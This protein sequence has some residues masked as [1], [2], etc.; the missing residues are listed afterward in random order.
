MI[1]PC[2][3]LQENRAFC[4]WK[5]KEY[6][7]TEIHWRSRCKN[8]S[9]YDTHLRTYAYSLT[10]LLSYTT[11]NCLN[12]RVNQ[13]SF[14]K[15]YIFTFGIITRKSTRLWSKNQRS[16]A[17][18]TWSSLY[19]IQHSL[20]TGMHWPGMRLYYFTIPPSQRGGTSDTA[21][22]LNPHLYKNHIIP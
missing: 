4:I 22:L 20:L 1:V 16:K 2:K 5:R 14:I 7:V 11:H 12:A 8:S 19:H 13:H 15:K 6:S 9:V 21:R 3:T 17:M 18:V 10:L